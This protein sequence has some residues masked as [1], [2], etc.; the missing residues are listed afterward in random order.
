ML[1][2]VHFLFL[3]LFGLSLCSTAQITIDEDT[4]VA[5]WKRG[6]FSTLTINQVS[7]T[8]WAAGGEN[9]FSATLLGSYFL[10]YRKDDTYFESVLDAGL[11]VISTKTERLS[12]NEDK[13]EIN[14]KFGKKIK[15]KFFY[16]GLL[17]FRTQFL[18]GYK[19]PDDSTIIS[20]FMAPG[21]LSLAV[22]VDY[23]PNDWFSVFLSP[24]TGR[25]TFVRNQTLADAGQ[26]GVT[27]AIRDSSGGII[28]QGKNARME[29]GAYLRSRLQKDFGTHYSVVSNLQLFNNYSDPIK[30]QRV[31]I[32]VNWETILMIKAN[33]W[34]TVSLFTNLVYDHDV[35][36]P[37]TRII[38]GNEVKGTGPRTQFKEVLGV[39]LSL[40]L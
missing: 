13:L 4:S 28:T 32:D 19:L 5:G 24:A 20:D 18:P 30:E 1:Q 31:N 35:Q 37:V 2:K 33:K 27:A 12:K 22:G 11:G 40:K 6:G 17:N 36:I 39:G 16:A 8:N 38:D 15:G 23:K 10:K 21:F 29:F 9:A 3:F 34:L 26:F 25:A 14:G 7:L